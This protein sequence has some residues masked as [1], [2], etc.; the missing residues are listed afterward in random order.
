MTKD[1]FE[2][3]LLNPASVFKSPEAV[4]EESSLTKRQKTEILLQW[5]YNAAEEAVALEEGMPGEETNMLHR[6][7]TALGQVAG[8]I[9]VEHT[10]PSKQHGLRET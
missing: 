3:A 10:G 6:V 5:E 9:D 7:L 2:Q 4:L 8:P 1:E